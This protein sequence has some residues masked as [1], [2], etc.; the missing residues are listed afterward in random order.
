MSPGNADRNLL[1]GILAHQNALITKEQLLAGMR[2]WLYD[3]AR[4]LAEILRDQG[5]LDESRRAL[6][7]ALVDHHVQQHG[8][9]PQQSLQAVSSAG[10][11]RRDLERL[12]DPELQASIIHLSQAKAD[13][14]PYATKSQSAG[15][16]TSAGTRFVILRPHAKGGLGEVY[17]ALD[18]EL[19]R[20]VALKE[21]QDKHADNLDSRARFLLEAEITGGLEH[22]SIVPVYGLG[23]YADGRPFYAMRFIR[24]DS[25]MDAIKRY[26][27][28]EPRASATGE[29][30]VELHKL[31]RRLIDV[32]NALQ[33]AHD[34]GVL[35]RD[36]KPGN[37]MLGKYGETLVVDWGLAKAT[38][39][40]EPE[41]SATDE[42]PLHPASGSGTAETIAG[43]AIGTPAYMS[44]EQ[45]EGRLDILGPATDV[46]SLGA[47]LY[48]LLTGKAP[49][50]GPLDEVLKKVRTGDITP[51]RR[52]DPAID[53]G[54][55]AVC[56]KA[57]EL[58]VA[59]RYASPHQ[60]A[61][62][63]EHWLADEPVVAYPEPWRARLARWTR[64]H[65][66]LV[67]AAVMLLVTAVAALSAGLFLLGQKQTE[68]VQERNA[69]RKAKDQAEAITRF[70]ED[71]V[72]AAARPKGWEG[73]GGKDVTLKEAID[74]AALKIDEAFAGQPELEAA[75]RN[76]LGM[77]YW[78]LG[79]FEAAN[80]HLEK[81]YALRRELL[82]DEHPDTLTS[83]HDLAR[84][85][86]RQDRVDE[87]ITTSRQA[88]E[89]RRRVL[90]PEH[91]DTLWT[92]LWLG[93]LLLDVND[94]EAEVLL[95]QAVESCKRTLGPDHRYTLHGQHDLAHA[96][97]RLGKV[98]EARTRYH[99]ALDGRRRAL[100]PEHPDTLRT[101]GSL[102][103][104]LGQL[105]KLDEAETL[106]RQSWEGR[107][108]V[109]GSD[110]IETFWAQ[111][112]LG[113]LL[114]QKGAYPEAE[115]LLR[116]CLAGQRKTLGTDHL[117]LSDT[118]APL[119]D[120]LARTGRAAEA[121]PLLRQCLAILEKR[122]PPGHW[123][124]ANAQSILGGTLARQ[125][126]FA[127]AEPLLL[128]GCE[129]L[130]KAKAA[131]PKQF[132]DASD[133][134]IDLYEKW[135]KPEQAEAW[136][137]KRPPSGK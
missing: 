32:C 125:D 113:A 56:L 98:E 31:L 25:L 68:V 75:V 19:N 29:R 38:G 61:D 133:R 105:G 89:K 106:C 7:D 115:K 104:F 36:I 52:L 23:T 27:Q 57:M 60:M 26:H 76:T 90:G 43:S 137:K 28:G 114:T 119:G 85:R 134:I 8:G 136:R 67:T 101:M 66:T 4:P 20:E 81:A 6:L 77:T 15:A 127:D 116:D 55:E 24:G 88:L 44:P 126:K 97:K 46:Y 129:G 48:A 108:R 124:L 14:D 130:T 107:R 53:A 103:L 79:Q 69:A 49:A 63:L 100:G 118:L 110:H 54:L 2:A 30:A 62:D 18:T 59:D 58:R 17:V 42:P 34:R 21:I 16:A 41:A 112:Y 123:D 128:T 86:W 10:S 83:L 47:T 82:G 1:L 22:P 35:H 45:A 102:G 87:A 117:D 13:D 39:K 122:F 78:Y 93:L 74:Q 92:Q 72:L 3:K 135:R 70:Y 5:A 65:K 64:R 33:Y 37:I 109:L 91:P 121:E 40:N 96:L 50:D 80:P 71:H 11:V 95:R 84:L 120:L 111:Q 131:R 132:A 12:P 51:P 94:E 99:E 73:G 9:D